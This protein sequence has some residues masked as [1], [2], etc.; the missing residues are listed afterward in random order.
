MDHEKYEIIA[1][2]L[3]VSDDL[4]NAVGLVSYYGLTFPVVFD[5]DGSISELYNI[6]SIPTNIFIG[7]DGIITQNILGGLAE[8]DILKHLEEGYQE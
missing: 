6:R 5:L 7:S 3:T 2:N 8:E 1:I 4:E